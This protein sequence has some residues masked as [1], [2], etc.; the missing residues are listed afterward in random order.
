MNVASSASFCS[1][2]FMYYSSI[3]V[4]YTARFR[5]LG[6]RS[7]A[8]LADSRFH[9]LE[10]TVRT[11]CKN[12]GEGDTKGPISDKI[13]AACD[14]MNPHQNATLSSTTNSTTLLHPPPLL[15][16]TSSGVHA[17]GRKVVPSL[18]YPAPPS[19][20]IPPYVS[21]IELVKGT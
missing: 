12:S 4:Y 16:E 5:H 3:F 20:S 17:A 21:D 7:Q 1:Y 9:F 18:R 8:I 10:E 2:F 13:N 19:P 14:A 11:H 6:N 15:S